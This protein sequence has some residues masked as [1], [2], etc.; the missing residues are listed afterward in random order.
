MQDNEKE[1]K[2]EIPVTRKKVDEDWKM[3]IK[4]EK[5]MLAAKQA[6]VKSILSDE[7]QKV[8]IEFLTSLLYQVQMNLGLI[9]NPMTGQ[10][11]IDLAQGQFMIDVLGAIDKKTKDTQTPEEKKLLGQALS[12]VRLLYTQIATQMT[13]S[14]QAKPKPKPAKK[15]KK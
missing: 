8:Y 5:E 2:L 15:K 6:E 9:E 13:S 12:D 4:Q 7:E 14:A 10:R 3:K 1:K 11:N